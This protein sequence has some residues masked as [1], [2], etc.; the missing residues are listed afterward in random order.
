MKRTSPPAHPQRQSPRARRVR[1]FNG[2]L[3]AGGVALLH[4]WT[5]RPSPLDCETGACFAPA[6]ALVPLAQTR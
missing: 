3:I 2:L 6:Q 1:F 5:N 4:A